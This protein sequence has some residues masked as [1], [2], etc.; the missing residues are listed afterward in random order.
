MAANVE[1]EK[2]KGINQPVVVLGLAALC[3]LVGLAAWVYQLSKGMVVTGLS[4]Q[5]SW[6]LY[7]AGF[8]T[9]A[10]AGGGL[11]LSLVRVSM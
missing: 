7:I 11:F 6:G 8:F 4:Q 5:I 10:G 2:K 1:M 9:A 3:S